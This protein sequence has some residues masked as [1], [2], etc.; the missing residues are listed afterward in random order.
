MLYHVEELVIKLEVQDLSQCDI[1]IQEVGRSSIWWIPNILKLF[2]GSHEARIQ[3]EVGVDTQ[4][5]IEFRRLK[6]LFLLYLPT[7][8]FVNFVLR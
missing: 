1:W 5:L 7:F 2:D 4:E 8:L 3:Q 6:E